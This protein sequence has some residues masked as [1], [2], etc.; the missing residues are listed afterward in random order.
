MTNHLRNAMPALSILWAAMALAMAFPAIADWATGDGGWQDVI[1]TAAVVFLVGSL[2]FAALRQDTQSWS[3]RSGILFVNLAWVSASLVGALPLYFSDLNISFIDAVFESVSGLTTTGSTVLIG[4]DSMPAGILLW[5]SMLQW[6]G[7]IGFVVI[8]TFLLPGV[9]SGGQQIFTLESSD[10]SDKEFGRFRHYAMRIVVLYLILS[11]ACFTA[12]L[13]LG[14]DAF[15]AINH[16]LTTVS[17]GGYSTSDLSMAQFDSEG[18]LWASTFFMFLSSLPFIYL[19]QLFLMGKHRFDPQVAYYCVVLLALSI[20]L[21]WMINYFDSP[22][23]YHPVTTAVFHIVSVIT[24]TGFAAEDYTGWHGSVV[25]FFFVITFL[26]GCSGSTSGGYKMYRLVVAFETVRYRLWQVFYPH[27]SR[28]PQYG[29]RPLKS[30]D[31]SNAMSFTFLFFASFAIVAMILQ[32]LGLDLVTSISASA[33]AFTNTGPGAGEIIG[34]VGNFQPLPASAKW[35][36]IAAM[37]VGRLEL[38]VV[39]VLAIRAFWQR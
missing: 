12:Y 16:A 22:T 3:P 33:T 21:V 14:M 9:G 32:L 25:A 28:R 23:A 10:T 24:T 17:T 4:L 39:Y 11:V 38:L 18:I 6:F 30:G 20:I 26:G 34:P 15:N 19:I 37:I 8:A 35:V 29:R 5:R 27:Y 31:I 36:L 7:G 1:A 13:F 2:S